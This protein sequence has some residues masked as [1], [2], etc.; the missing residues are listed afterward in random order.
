LRALSIGHGA[1]DLPVIVAYTHPG[2]MSL[3]AVVD[4]AEKTWER[5]GHPIDGFVEEVRM[6]DARISDRSVHCLQ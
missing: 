4:S 2:G 1:L 3:A 6:L 5:T